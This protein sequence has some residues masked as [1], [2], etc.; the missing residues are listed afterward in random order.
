MI[1][2]PDRPQQYPWWTSYDPLDGPALQLIEQLKREGKIRFCGL[3][4]TTV[5]EMTSL[6]ES[7]RFDVV[8]TAFNYNALYREPTIR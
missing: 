2:E 4:G 6:V 1:H 8:L 7:D 5:T 3:A